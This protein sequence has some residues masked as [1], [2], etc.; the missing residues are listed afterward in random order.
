[1]LNI[2]ELT[3]FRRARSASRMATAAVILAL[4]TA[5]WA[6]ALSAPANADDGDGG[7]PSITVTGEPGT[8]PP[9]NSTFQGAIPVPAGV[10]LDPAATPIKIHGGTRPPSESNGTVPNPPADAEPCEACSDGSG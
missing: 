2:N 1:M 5:G 4:G 6:A 10:G 9:G 3:E 8:P 7:V